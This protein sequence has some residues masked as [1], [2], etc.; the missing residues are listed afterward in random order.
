MKK[1][2]NYKNSFQDSNN[3][4]RP[5]PIKFLYINKLKLSGRL[6]KRIQK[7]QTLQKNNKKALNT[8]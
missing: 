6:N 2:I 4:E 8:N 3:Q 1:Q 5:Y 7:L